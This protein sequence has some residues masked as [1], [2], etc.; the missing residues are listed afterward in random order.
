MLLRFASPL[1]LYFEGKLDYL[2]QCLHGRGGGAIY[3]VYRKGYKVLRYVV[4]TVR[5][6]VAMTH[7]RDGGKKKTADI[8]FYARIRYQHPM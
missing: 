2:V 4:I 3:E 5:A 7:V 6:T 8:N 1:P